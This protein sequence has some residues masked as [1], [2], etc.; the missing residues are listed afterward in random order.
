M[1]EVARLN[2]RGDVNADRL[3]GVLREYPDA[4]L[5]VEGEWI[6]VHSDA[7]P[8]SHPINVLADVV[9]VAWERGAITDNRFNEASAAIES[10]EEA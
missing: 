9:Q 7:R 5:R 8:V 6:T 10:L 1:S 4:T 3:S 2:G